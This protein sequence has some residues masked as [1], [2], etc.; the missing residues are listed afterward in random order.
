MKK[1]TL[2][3]LAL[4]STAFLAAPAKAAEDTLSVGVGYYDILENDDQAADFR[5]EYR[6][7][8]NAFW[9]LKPFAG[10]EFTTDGA[11][12]GLG[13]LYMD[14][15][16]TDNVF[17]IPQLGAGIYSDGDGKDLG[18]GI[19]FRSQLELAYRFAN[20]TRMGLAFSHTSNAGLGD[21]N[22]GVEVLSLYYHIPVDWF[23]S[24]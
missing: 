15:A 24:Y 23:T 4:A 18:H 13:G 1:F 12:Y 22:P 6:W 8:N 17:L 2:A 20:H 11:I 7:A 9:K 19:E 3:L 16:L 14:L 21:D 10:L 5:A